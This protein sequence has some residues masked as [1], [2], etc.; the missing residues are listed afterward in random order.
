[1]SRRL[2][3]LLLLPVLALLAGAG[4]APAQQGGP[5]D[6]Q[7]LR[8]HI[9][10]NS[11]HPADITA[12][13][14]VRTALLGFLQSR[15]EGMTSAEAAARR[16][17]ALTPAMTRIA[18]ETLSGY[19]LPYAAKVA[20]GTAKLPT[21]RYLGQSLK[22]GRYLTLEVVLGQGHGQNWW[23]MLFPELCLSDGG[24]AVGSSEGAAASP[25]GFLALG[26]R[27]VVR[28]PVQVRPSGLIWRFWELLH[29]E[30]AHPELRHP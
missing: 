12:K 27:S 22:A 20:V 17:E 21:R 14:A 29:P 13:V 1:M 11:N 28:S 6:P 5:A 26:K 18:N 3:A 9:V 4:P 19:G 25:S 24:A 10:A 8:L 15:L 2:G 16:L 23:C 7:V 30:Q